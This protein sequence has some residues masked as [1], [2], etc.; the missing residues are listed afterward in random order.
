MWF[1][2]VSGGLVRH[3]CPCVCVLCLVSAGPHYVCGVFFC[4]DGCLF[5]N[6]LNEFK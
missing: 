4:G 5:H 6:M 3:F 1:V 2:G